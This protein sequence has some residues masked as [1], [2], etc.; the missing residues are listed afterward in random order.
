MHGQSFFRYLI[1]KKSEV[2]DF[3]FKDLLLA[4]TVIDIHRHKIDTRLQYVELDRLVS[5]HAIDRK[6]AIKSLQQ[7]CRQLKKNR[8]DIVKAGDI[9]KQQILDY[10][11]SISGIKVVKVGNTWVA[12]EG[13]GRLEAFKSVFKHVNNIR[14]EVEV[15]VVDAQAKICRRVRRVQRYNRLQ[16]G[17]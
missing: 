8:T 1:A 11:P 3:Q 17:K 7:R 13:N 5:I 2:K 6:N 10:M 15:F 9:S 4:K 14:L 16:M 12:F